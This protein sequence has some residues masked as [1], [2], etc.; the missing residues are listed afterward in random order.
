MTLPSWRGPLEVTANEV[1]ASWSQWL[2][3]EALE[4][5]F[6]DAVEILLEGD[7]FEF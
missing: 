5:R 4:K 2:V 6:E 1:S 3:D 7:A